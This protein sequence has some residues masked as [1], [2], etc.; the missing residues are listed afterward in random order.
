MSSKAKNL[1]YN[2]SAPIE[3]ED[4]LDEHSMTQ[5]PVHIY[6]REAPPGGDRNLA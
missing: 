4:S 1:V 3:L 2:A 6:T 5:N